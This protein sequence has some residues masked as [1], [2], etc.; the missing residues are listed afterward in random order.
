MCVMGLISARALKQ[1]H[2]L[3]LSLLFN[4]VYM[5]RWRWQF[6][7]LK[8]CK[9]TYPISCLSSY[10]ACMCMCVFVPVSRELWITELSHPCC[11][12][13]SRPHCHRDMQ[14][15]LFYWLF[16]CWSDARQ[17]MLLCRYSNL[18]AP[19]TSS[20]AHPFTAFVHLSVWSVMQ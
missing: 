1:R 19:M 17:V 18:P 8:S 10:A 16:G 14:P 5:G 13:I 11:E 6:S 9:A 4:Y 7:F 2:A 15:S 3:W 20:P 12:R